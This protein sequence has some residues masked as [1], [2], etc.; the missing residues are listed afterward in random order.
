MVA[1][2][3]EINSARKGKGQIVNKKC[4]EYYF[5]RNKLKFK[6]MMMLNFFNQNRADTRKK[7]PETPKDS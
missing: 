4:Y 1:C 3:G 7:I 5:I 2:M 6:Q